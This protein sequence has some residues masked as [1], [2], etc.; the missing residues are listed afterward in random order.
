MAPVSGGALCLLLGVATVASAERV[1]FA[2]DHGWRFQRKDEGGGG[3]QCAPSDFPEV[4][5]GTTSPGAGVDRSAGVTTEAQCATA[6]CNC[7]AVHRAKRHQAI[8]FEQIPSEL[9][10]KCNEEARRYQYKIL[11][12]QSIWATLGDLQDH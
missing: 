3:E 7:G 12:F 9:L 6:C 10:C 11:S 2:L 8:R 4:R 1:V 5:D